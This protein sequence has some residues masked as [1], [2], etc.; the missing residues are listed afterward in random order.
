MNERLST[1]NDVI[2]NA[3]GAPI[4]FEDYKAYHNAKELAGGELLDSEGKRI[5]LKDF[6]R[7]DRIVPAVP[8][9]DITLNFTED[10]MRVTQYFERCMLKELQDK[11]AI[12]QKA[13]EILR[14]DKT[15]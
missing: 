8:E 4:T 5:E 12:L 3:N 2:F 9:H 11:V 1:P 6:V 15:A 13:I 10:D 14:T 7:E